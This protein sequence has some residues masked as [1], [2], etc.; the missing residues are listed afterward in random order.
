[1]EDLTGREFG[2]IKV[3][4]FSGRVKN[5]YYWNCECLGCGKKDVKKNLTRIKKFGCNCFYR[6]YKEL[7]DNNKMYRA[8]Q[9]IKTRCLN[10]NS[11]SFKNYGGRG[12]KICNEWFEFNNF[13]DWAL[14]TGYKK[15]LTIDRI[16]VNGDYCPENCRWATKKVQA[17]N[18]RSNIRVTMNGETHTLIE[19]SR[20][21]KI[22][23]RTVQSRIY[24]YGWRIEDA[25]KKEVNQSR[26]VKTYTI[27]GKT[28]T[29]YEWANILDIGHTTLWRRLKKGMKIEEALGIKS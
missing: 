19:W 13:Y 21:Y 25:I 11:K 17:N 29:L 15:G 12:I 14:K 4:S 7:I 26:H 27:N 3:L 5:Q 2:M 24:I 10:K 22:N 28:H 20:I 23:Y 18:S 16:D 8:W 9:G 6:K 1:M